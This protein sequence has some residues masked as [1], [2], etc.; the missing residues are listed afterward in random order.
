MHQLG[1][2]LSKTPDFGVPGVDLTSPAS[3]LGLEQVGMHAYE[4]FGASSLE[5]HSAAAR[6]VLATVIEEVL[7][8]WRPAR[9]LAEALRAVELGEI[10]AILRPGGK[11]KHGKAYTLQKMRDS[12]ACRCGIPPRLRDYGGGSTIP[13]GGALHVAPD[14]AEHLAD[15]PTAG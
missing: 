14:D 2:A 3:N 4:F 13:G 5:N 8:F 10:Q 12:S 7:G 1:V 6:S 15:A 11:G 9:D